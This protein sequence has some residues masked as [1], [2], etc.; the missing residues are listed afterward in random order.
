MNSNVDREHATEPARMQ[1][2]VLIC[3]E[4][5]TLHL[6]DGTVSVTI[7]RVGHGQVRLGVTAPREVTV[8]REEIY[9]LTAGA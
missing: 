2:Q 5:E 1:V 9:S 7:S 8:H 3:D 6:G 4:G